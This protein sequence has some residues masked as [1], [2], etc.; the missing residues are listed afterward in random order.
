MTMP[1]PLS[2]RF[3]S[4]VDRRSAD[5]CWPWLGSKAASGHGKILYR[6][7][8]NSTTNAHR[9]S[10]ELHHGPIPAGMY[11][12]HDCDNGWCVNPSHL[13]LGTHRD[14]MREAGNRGLLARRPP[15][16]VLEIDANE[17]R[18]RYAAGESQ[19]AIANDLGIGQTSVSRMVRRVGHWA[20]SPQ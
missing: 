7:G 17:V 19:Q 2:E 16:R 4:K 20:S 3:W 12:L 14:N 13:H 6:S 5:E 1:S 15:T 10:W 9:V 8:V 11:V 18:A